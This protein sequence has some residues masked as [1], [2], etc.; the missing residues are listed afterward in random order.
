MIFCFF[1]NKFEH[2]SKNYKSSLPRPLDKYNN[3]LSQNNN[4]L[5]Y[6]IN[7]FNNK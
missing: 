5:S 2:F 4:F 6:G 7:T 1:F 3:N